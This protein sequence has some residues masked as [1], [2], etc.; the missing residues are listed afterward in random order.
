RLRNY[1]ADQLRERSNALQRARRE[2]ARPPKVVKSPDTRRA[3]R[4]AAQRAR[5][6]E[7]NLL[8]PQKASISSV[9]TTSGV[10]KHV[11]GDS[12]TQ[13]SESTLTSDGPG[14]GSSSDNSLTRAVTIKTGS[15]LHK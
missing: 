4:A 2:A 6:W 3:E 15:L 12:D 9:A 5:R 10:A 8:K 7:A 13:E 1:T 11:Q 14:W